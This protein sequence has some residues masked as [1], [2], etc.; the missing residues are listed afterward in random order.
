MPEDQRGFGDAL[1]VEASDEEI[2]F[3]W[4]EP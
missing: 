4:T 1:R 2:V 3:Y